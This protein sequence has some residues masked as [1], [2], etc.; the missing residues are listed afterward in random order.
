MN[1][2]LPILG[3]KISRNLGLGG[4]GN[5]AAIECNPSCKNYKEDQRMNISKG[6]QLVHLLFFLFFDCFDMESKIVILYD[7]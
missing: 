7:D 3:R 6:G 2:I 1:C 5:M 4:G